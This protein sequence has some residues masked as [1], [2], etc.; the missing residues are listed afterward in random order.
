MA[1]NWFLPMSPQWAPGRCL[2]SPSVNYCLLPISVF[3]LG[4]LRLLHPPACLQDLSQLGHIPIPRLLWLQRTQVKH[5][6]LA[7]GGKVAPSSLP[8]WEEDN[9]YSTYNSVQ[10]VLSL[11]IAR[12]SFVMSQNSFQTILCKSC[13]DSR[14]A[15]PFRMWSSGHIVSLVLCLFVQVF[16]AFLKNVVQCVILLT[17]DQKKNHLTLL[18]ILETFSFQ[19]SHNWTAMG[20]LHNRFEPQ[21]LYQ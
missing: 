3:L 6:F 20:N 8:L 2:C 15:P 18:L 5:S 12:T 21:F 11:D 19:I 16:L 17:L 10:K 13:I 14:W 4:H 7:T 1:P 9:T